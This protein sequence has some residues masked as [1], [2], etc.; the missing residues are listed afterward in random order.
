MIQNDHARKTRLKKIIE[1]MDAEDK[2]AQLT[3][4]VGYILLEVAGS[5]KT[6]E[7]LEGLTGERQGVEA[8]A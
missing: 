1:I 6:R 3:Q 5:H 7:M 2:A 4:M 8:P